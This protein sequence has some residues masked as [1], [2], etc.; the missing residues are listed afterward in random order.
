MNRYFICLLLFSPL[1][2]QEASP[3]FGWTKASLYM[4]RSDKRPF[5]I[6]LDPEMDFSPW[7]TYLP[8]WKRIY[9]SDQK[10]WDFT[11][12]P[13]FHIQENQVRTEG[14]LTLS[15]IVRELVGQKVP[16]EQWCTIYDHKTGILKAI[17]WGTFSV[18]GEPIEFKDYSQAGGI[19]LD[20]KGEGWNEIVEY[21][22]G[23]PAREAESQKAIQK[24]MGKPA[25]RASDFTK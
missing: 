6:F 16:Y 5:R 21:I 9:P 17:R 14:N 23:E 22:K 8:E 4:T 19:L 7:G 3:T 15:Y 25:K 18:D 11:K 24:L 10:Q 12:Q 13:R 20:L 2:A 1:V